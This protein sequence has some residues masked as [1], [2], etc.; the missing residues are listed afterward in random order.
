MLPRSNLTLRISR[1]CKTFNSLFQHVRYAFFDR[2]KQRTEKSTFLWTTIVKFA[3]IGS[4]RHRGLQICF[5]L[6]LLVWRS[7]GKTNVDLVQELYHKGIL[8]SDVVIRTMKAID[9]KNYCPRAKYP[10]DDVP[11]DIGYKATISAPHMHA[12]AL[13]LLKDHLT[14]GESALDI[15]SGSGYITVCMAVMLGEQGLAIGVEH[16]P[17]LVVESTNNIQKHQPWLLTTGRVKIINADG[18]LG[19][20]KHAPY[21]AIHIGATIPDIPQKILDQLKPGGRLVAPIGSGT[22][23]YLT[24]VDRTPAGRIKTKRLM[25]VMF[26][27]LTDKNDQLGSV[28]TW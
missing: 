3:K 24:V 2:P 23:Q 5:I 20:N 28:N 19:Y 26:V 18:R 8:K 27:P 6:A 13:E 7:D 12:Y 1:D 4:L 14:N 21:N 9:R 17:E 22:D 10:Y 15:G 11:Q 16:I 25:G